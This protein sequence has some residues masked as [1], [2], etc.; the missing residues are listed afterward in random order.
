LLI[1]SDGVSVFIQ[2]E[3]VSKTEGNNANE[4][5][6]DSMD[7]G[8]SGKSASTFSFP[9]VTLS[10]IPTVHI[11]SLEDY[12]KKIPSSSVVLCNRQAFIRLSSPDSEYYNPA[13]VENLMLIVFD[14]VHEA[15]KCGEIRGEFQNILR[16]VR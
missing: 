10:C 3:Q 1:R 14:N 15:L 5:G 9:F 6:N 12:R 8:P 4:D 2:E 7:D 13:F 11:N 16:I